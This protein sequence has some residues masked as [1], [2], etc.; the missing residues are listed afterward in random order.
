[1]VEGPQRKAVSGWSAAIWALGER[2]P[3]CWVFVEHPN[4][5]V[6]CQLFTARFS[7][8]SRGD[9]AA[10]LLS[11]WVVGLCL[12]GKATKLNHPLTCAVKPMQLNQCMPPHKPLYF[13][14]IYSSL[15]SACSQPAEDAQG[16]AEPPFLDSYWFMPTGLKS[17]AEIFANLPDPGAPSAPCSW[18]FWGSW[19]SQHPRK[20][21][22]LSHVPQKATVA[23]LSA[24]QDKFIPGEIPGTG[25]HGGLRYQLKPL[26]CWIKI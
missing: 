13:N 25:S 16:R 7:P 6:A 11:K 26:L 21:C 20:I 22:F 1:M 24:V 12:R 19:L 8:G 18:V 4:G 9:L 3:S 10:Q 14:L 2:G 5:A 15:T 23:A 17:S